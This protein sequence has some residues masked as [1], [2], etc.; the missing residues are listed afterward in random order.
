MGILSAIGVL[1]IIL[2][3]GFRITVALLLVGLLLLVMGCSTGTYRMGTASE[4]A[5]YAKVHCVTPSWYD[6]RSRR[7]RSQDTPIFW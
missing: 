3:L 6:S 5:Q 4:D 2:L 7:C 1:F